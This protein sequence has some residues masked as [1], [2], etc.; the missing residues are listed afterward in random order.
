M[1]VSIRN[2]FEI[3]K[4]FVGRFQECI[5]I[6]NVVFDIQPESQS[7]NNDFDFNSSEFSSSEF[8]F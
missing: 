8:P 6:L 1:L 5:I 2:S 7:L 3:E 4:D